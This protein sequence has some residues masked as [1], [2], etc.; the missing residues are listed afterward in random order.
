[1]QIADV[2]VEDL[3]AV[4]VLNEA[5]VPHLSSLTADELSWF[6]DQANYFRVVK[7]DDGLA[8]FLIGLRPGLPYASANYRWFARH[9]EDFGY[10]DRVAVHHT[11][12]R[13]GVASLLYND[14]AAFLSGEV[15]V[16]TCE[17][18]LRPANESSMEYHLRHGF[19]QVGSQDTEEP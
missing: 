6:A 2:T 16:M 5:S 14:F 19:V 17:V 10:V 11:A 7:M 8:G 13:R 4:L 9:Y 15:A 12:R 18:N 3:P 1:M